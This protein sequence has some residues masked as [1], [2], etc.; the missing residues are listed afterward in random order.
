MAML[1][2]NAI[3]EAKAAGI[4]ELDFGRSEVENCGLVTYKDH[5]G[6]RRS[7]MNYWRHPAQAAGSMRGS[8]LNNVKGLISI[9]PDASLVMLGRFLYRHVG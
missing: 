4:E 5:W 2:W 1:F 6:T 3:Q 7:T 9:A 8:A